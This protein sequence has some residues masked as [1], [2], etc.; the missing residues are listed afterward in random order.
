MATAPKTTAIRVTSRSPKG[1]IWRAGRQW[2]AE[3]TTVSLTE[4]SKEQ[5]VALR[6]EPLLHVEDVQLGADG[7]VTKA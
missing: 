5:V 2:S 1:A 7:E 4:L 3:P 6:E